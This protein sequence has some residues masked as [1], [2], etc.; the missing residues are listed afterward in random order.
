MSTDLARQSEKERRSRKR[1]RRELSRPSTRGRV[2]RSACSLMRH[3]RIRSVGRAVKF[4]RATITRIFPATREPAETLGVLA[5][6]RMCRIRCAAGDGGTMPLPARKS[7][8]YQDVC[9]FRGGRRGRN[10]VKSKRGAG[11]DQA[12][13]KADPAKSQ[14]PA[15]SKRDIPA[16]RGAAPVPDLLE[17]ERKAHAETRRKL[18]AAREQTRRKSLECD[19]IKA[20]FETALR[21]AQIH[22]YSQ[23]RDLR[24]TW[25]YNPR[26]PDAGGDHARAHRR[27]I[28]VVARAAGGDRGEAAGARDRR[29]GRLRGVLHHAGAARAVRAAYRSDLRRPTGASKASCARRST[30]AASARSKASAGV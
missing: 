30:S 21:G 12:D 17:R 23:D 8:A 7:V 13:R 6:C 20:R 28:V 3:R 4:P 29:A 1:L 27:R 25:L 5:R 18:K 19:E 11:R 22:V 26:D 24:Y 14:K 2:R 16:R 10:V 15:T 9:D